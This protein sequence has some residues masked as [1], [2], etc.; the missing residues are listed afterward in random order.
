MGMSK[1]RKTSIIVLFAASI[2]LHIAFWGGMWY[3]TKDSYLDSTLLPNQ[4]KMILYDCND[5]LIDQDNYARSAEIS[6]QVKHAFIAVEDKRFYRHHGI[7]L[8]RVM[9]AFLS[10]IKSGSLR[11]GGSTITCQLAKNTHLTNEKTLIRKIKEAKIALQ[12]ERAYS[13]EQILEM[14]LNAIYFGHGIYGI[15][16]ASMAYFNKTPDLINAREAA[17]LAAIIANP[18]RYS[19]RDCFEENQHRATMILSLMNEQGLLSSNK[20]KSA[21]HSKIIIYYDNFHNNCTEIYTISSLSEAQ[22]ILKT[23]AYTQPLHVFTYLDPSIESAARRAIESYS[24]DSTLSCEIMIADNQTHGIS[25]H[26]STG[27]GK[28]IKRQPG[29]LLKPFIYSTAI[30]NNILIPSTPI[31]DQPMN[32]SGYTPKNYK[33]KTYGWIDAEYA[34]TQSLNVPAVSLLQRIGIEKGFSDI[35]KSGIPLSNQDKNLAL[36]LGGTTDGST[37]SEICGGYLTLASSGCYTKPTFIRKITDP[38]GNVLYRHT[39]T[40]T[41]VYSDET[42]YLTTTMLIKSAQ[43]GTAKQL[44]TLPFEIAAKTGT[45]AVKNGNSDAWCAGYTTEHTLVCRYSGTG[46]SPLPDSFTGGNIPTKTLRATLKGIYKGHKPQPFPRPIGIQSIAID[47]TV[48][49]ELHKLIPYTAQSIG[50][51]QTILTTARYPLDSIDADMFFFRDLRTIPTENGCLILCKELENI[52]YKAYLNGKECPHTSEGFFAEQQ[53]F[54]LAKLEL[55]CSRAGK[56]IY[57]TTKIIRIG[58]SLI[59]SSESRA[60]FI[61]D[62]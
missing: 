10:N 24:T 7:D 39:P 52:D 51:S 23:E 44:A 17:T 5:Q 31:Y 13:K 42:T 26:L 53:F 14:Y 32:F 4:S 49:E 33:N 19:P 55:V 60:S 58:H 30:E 35:E 11:E 3:I 38:K 21:N 9:G 37:V 16:N 25:T 59:T 50:E 22:A 6:E 54:P 41:C 36:A 12:I 18:S 46:H 2:F 45:V 8:K 48:K 61:N 28:N 56:P 15:K 20:L 43:T 40:K 27:L 29:S 62:S 1:V 47:R 57:K 34:L